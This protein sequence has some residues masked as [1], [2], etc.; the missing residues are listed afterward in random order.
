MKIWR[1]WNLRIMVLQTD[2]DGENLEEVADMMQDRE[3]R[4]LEQLRRYHRVPFMVQ[5]LDAEI[6]DL[7]AMVEELS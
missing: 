2:G 5:F 7:T 3:R 6:A 4:L 1:A